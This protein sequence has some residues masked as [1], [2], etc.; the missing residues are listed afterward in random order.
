[1]FSRT[2]P[3]IVRP[4]PTP[5]PSPMRNPRRGRGTSSRS[6]AAIFVLFLGFGIASTVGSG[7]GLLVGLTRERHSLYLYITQAA[8][9]CCYTFMQL[10]RYRRREA[11]AR[12][13]VSTILSG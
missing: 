10:V 5:P 4:L 8:S 9:I 6:R 2:M 7:K 12:D 3:A 11:A 13:D 1:M